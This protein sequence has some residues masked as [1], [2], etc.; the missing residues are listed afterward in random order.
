M[1][2]IIN[3]LTSDLF[4]AVAGVSMWLGWEWRRR[5]DTASLATGAFKPHLVFLE[6]GEKKRRN[7]L[8][9]VENLCQTAKREVVVARRHTTVAGALTSRAWFSSPST[10]KEGEIAQETPTP[11]P[12]LKAIASVLDLL[13][14]KPFPGSSLDSQRD[15]AGL[16][17]VHIWTEP[18]WQ[19]PSAQSHA[20]LG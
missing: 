2:L 20:T 14:W 10:L 13:D 8:R 5:G 3:T 11:P 7:F 9:F 18:G 1:R 4:W 6:G 12:P 19:S 15:D 17:E 16:R